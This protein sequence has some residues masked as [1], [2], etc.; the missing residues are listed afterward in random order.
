MFA[1]EAAHGNEHKR[2][3]RD[4]AAS[5]VD[6]ELSPKRP[7]MNVTIIIL[8]LF[9]SKLLTSITRT[10]PHYIIRL[11]FGECRTIIIS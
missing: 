7:T 9:T 5:K 3:E 6:T 8:L 10:N 1:Y 4:T 2:N 11:A